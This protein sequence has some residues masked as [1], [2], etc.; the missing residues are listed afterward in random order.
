MKN[1]GRYVFEDDGRLWTQFNGGLKRPSTV[2]EMEGYCLER[3]ATPRLVPS[4]S[5]PEY[6]TI[7]MAM[8]V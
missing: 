7:P 1:T 6:D 8:A 2:E 4:V 5:Q 3:G